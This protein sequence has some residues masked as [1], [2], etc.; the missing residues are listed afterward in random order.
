MPNSTRTNPTMARCI[1]QAFA[2]VS[3][4]VAWRIFASDPITGMLAAVVALVAVAGIGEF[5]HGPIGSADE[6]KRDI[7]NELARRDRE[8]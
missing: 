4:L 7:L 2:V 1:W 6:V 8:N 5:R 3:A